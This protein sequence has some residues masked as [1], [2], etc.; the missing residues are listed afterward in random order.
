MCTYT[1]DSGDENISGKLLPYN[2][3]DL[4]WAKFSLEKI[5]CYAVVGAR[6]Q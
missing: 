4:S 1:I 2:T 5:T 6:G 3:L